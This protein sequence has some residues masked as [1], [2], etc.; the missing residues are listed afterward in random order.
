MTW[1]L[2]IFTD[3]LNLIRIDPQHLLH[4]RSTETKR[5]KGPPQ[6]K[7]TLRRLF[8]PSG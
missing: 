2:R 1:M 4:P 7:W 3:I 5:M 6:R 8:M